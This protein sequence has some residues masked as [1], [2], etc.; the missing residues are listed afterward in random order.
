VKWNDYDAPRLG[1]ALAYYTMLSM[2]PLMVL[3]VGICGLVFDRTSAERGLLIQVHQF[4]GTAGASTLAGLLENAHHRGSGILASTTALITLLL[5]ASGMF[6]ELRNS[7]NLIWG[8]RTSSTSIWGVFKERLASFGMVLGLG[9][10]LLLSLVLSTCFT[11][12]ER[13]FSGLIPFHAVLWGETANML[14]TFFA[15]AFLFGLI[16]RYVPDVKI[17]PGD[18]V[19]GALI[20]AILFS[21]GKFLLALYLGTAGVGSTYGAAGSL[22]AFVVWVYYSAQ[23]FLFGAIVTRVYADSLGSHS[24]RTHVK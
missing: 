10:L 20:T 11:I 17:A 8:A 21:I 1:A 23:I 9:V 18:V 2:A 16:F 6:V 24:F 7:L 14:I 13:L 19:T 22:I 3:M 12:I 5:G 4:T 15:T